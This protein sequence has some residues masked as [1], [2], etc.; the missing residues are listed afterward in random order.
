MLVGLLGMGA[1]L[2][3]CCLDSAL[4]ASE[5]IVR[6]QRLRSRLCYS[7]RAIYTLYYEREGMPKRDLND[8][9]HEAARILSVDAGR[10][11]P[12][13]RLCG[14][15][16]LHRSVRGSCSDVGMLLRHVTG[17]LAAK[18]LPQPDR[19]ET[20]DDIVRSLIVARIGQLR[21]AIDGATRALPA[22][23]AF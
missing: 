8:A 7:D 3:V 15:L 22:G 13:D 20:F 1:A 12:N 2:S 9:W 10:L 6:Q 5:R 21:P 19:F 4:E 16:G 18:G 17:K 23:T 11:R 14:E